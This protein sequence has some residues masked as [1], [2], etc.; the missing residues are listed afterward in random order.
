M[1][2]KENKVVYLTYHNGEAVISSREEWE[3]SWLTWWKRI[4]SE[5]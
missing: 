3:R 4:S 2:K 1:S 5:E